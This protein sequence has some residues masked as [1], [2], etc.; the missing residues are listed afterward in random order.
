MGGVN[1]AVIAK[2]LA[3]SAIVTTAGKTGLLHGATLTAAAA[4]ATLDLANGG[5]SGTKLWSLHVKA[6]EGCN[7]ITF[8]KPISF[9]TDIYAVIA[10]TGAIASIAYEEIEA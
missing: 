4:D 2:R 10:G 6:E 3:A 8:P 9:S 7:S 5:A 1:R